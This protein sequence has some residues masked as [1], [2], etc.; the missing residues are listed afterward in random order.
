[1]NNPEGSLFLKIK[2]VKG[3]FKVANTLKGSD[4]KE[5]SNK[6]LSKETAQK[7]RDAILI[8]YARKY[9]GTN[10]DYYFV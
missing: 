9:G 10:K 3:G 6:P 2:K 1:M 5:Y 7:Q 4:Y 8:P